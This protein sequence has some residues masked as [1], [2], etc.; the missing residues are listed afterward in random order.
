MAAEQDNKKVKSVAVILAAGSSSRMG[1]PK[2]LLKI[3]AESLIRKTIKT[4]LNSN[5]D[6]VIV[7]LGSNQPTHQN[8]IAD[9]PIQIIINQDWEQ[10]IGS[11][12]KSG[13]QFANNN[14]PQY[15]SILLTVC[16]QPLLTSD[17]LMKMI[18][19]FHTEDKSI[20][21]SF[22]SNS[23]G[24]PALFDRSMSEKLLNLDDGHG[25]KKVI[26]DNI[27]SAHLIDFP[28]GDVDLD[29]HGDW[30]KFL[31]SPQ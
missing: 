3:G 22:Y 31:K 10:G 25:A 28:K 4:V 1:K 8:E 11:S 30:E 26:Q 14:F 27:K 12:I 23:P 16:D 18:Q 7:V 13:I 15:E 6:Q 19:A 5:V 20:V 21:A 29:T 24:V 9:L 17:H 2:Q